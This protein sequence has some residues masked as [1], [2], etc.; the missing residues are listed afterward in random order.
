MLLKK[1]SC[2]I[3]RAKQMNFKPHQ[4]H[5]A[6]TSCQRDVSAKRSC[7]F[8]IKIT[9][10][11][12]L[13]LHNVFLKTQR[14]FLFDS[15]TFTILSIN[16]PTFYR[17]CRSLIR[18][19]AHYLFCRRLRVLLQGMVVNIVAAASLRFLFVSKKDIEILNNMQIQID[20]Y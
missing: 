1:Y 7:I 5:K 6:S 11:I 9:P 18:F 17:D 16:L 19:A 20:L 3:T 12:L 4:K 2:K 15:L 10:F 13:V 8:I 14:T